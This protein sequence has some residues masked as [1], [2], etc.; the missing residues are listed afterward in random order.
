MSALT[1]IRNWMKPSHEADYFTVAK[2]ATRMLDDYRDAV[3]T[4][5][6]RIELGGILSGLA[7]CELAMSRACEAMGWNPDPTP[8][9]PSVAESTRL[10]GLLTQEIAYCAAEGQEYRGV[11][12]RE[13]ETEPVAEALRSLAVAYSRGEGDPGL[14]GVGQAL[15]GL[16]HAVADVIHSQAAEVLVPL[17]IAHR[18]SPYACTCP[19]CAGPN[20]ENAGLPAEELRRR[21]EFTRGC[22]Q[23]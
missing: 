17:M 16:D 20:G 5:D 3:V 15:S 4:G 10:S 9:E 7:G 11:R 6:S 18:Y 8:A 23:P 22:D 12:C 1:R 19:A 14:P 2:V 13:L 21:A